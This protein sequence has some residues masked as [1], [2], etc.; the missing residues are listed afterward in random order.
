MKKILWL[1]IIIYLCAGCSTVPKNTGLNALW[2]DL[3]PFSENFDNAL[4]ECKI[5]LADETNRGPSMTFVKDKL[6]NKVLS[7]KDQFRLALILNGLRLTATNVEYAQ[8]CDLIKT[9]K[10]HK[11]FYACTVMSHDPQSF[12]CTLEILHEDTYIAPIVGHDG[13]IVQKDIIPWV[14]Y[15]L[16][17]TTGEKFGSDY[18]KWK[19]WWLQKGQFLEYDLETEKYIEAEP[20]SSRGSPGHSAFEYSVKK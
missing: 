4:N 15:D 12:L 3:H 10:K 6:Q 5:I 8:I 9:G 20:G 7:W 2:K 19:V 17:Q 1:A 13:T 16:E 11:A 14:V 18:D